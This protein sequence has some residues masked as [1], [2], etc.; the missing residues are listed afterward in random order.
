MLID[1][2]ACPPTTLSQTPV[3]LQRVQ[4]GEEIPNLPRQ[5]GLKLT[6]SGGNQKVF[7]GWILEN[8]LCTGVW[9]CPRHLQEAKPGPSKCDI[10]EGCLGLRPRMS[11]KTRRIV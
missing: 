3:C 6:I 9:P 2:R 10:T 8:V 1:P 7:L 5:K 4:D 11:F